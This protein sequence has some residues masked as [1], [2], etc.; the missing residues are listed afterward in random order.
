MIDRRDAVKASLTVIVGGRPAPP[1]PPTLRG[2]LTY[3][4]RETGEMGGYGQVDVI[5]RLDGS[6]IVR[7]AR[8][9]ADAWKD[10]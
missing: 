7:P 6:F 2:W 8:S 9:G 5:P 1:P 3:Q 4:N 10:R